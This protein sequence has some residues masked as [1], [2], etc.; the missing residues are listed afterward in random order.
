MDDDSRSPAEDIP[1]E[2]ERLFA[3]VM[4][5]L[6]AA[7]A[8][9][10]AGSDKASG[11]ARAYDAELMALRDEIGEARLEDVPA[12][13]AQMERL[14]EVSLTRADLQTMLVDPLSPYFGHLRL[15]ERVAGRGEVEREVFIGRATF[16]D[17]RTR[18]AIVDWRNAPV[19]Q[20]YYRYAEGSDYEETFGEREVEGDVLVRRT[21][22]IQDGTL[23]RIACP[24]GIWVKRRLPDQDGARSGSA[25]TCPCASWRAA[26]APPPG[27]FLVEACWDLPAR[28]SNDLTGTCPRSQRSSTRASSRS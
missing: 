3:R 24:Q 22:T 19:S 21:V 8:Q 16:T 26:N 18:I 1:A 25:R 11:R 10:P 4:Q 2:E 15:R 23:L 27:L 9:K 13:I 20:L 6:A 14:Q 12:L 5:S 28:T 17:P 7:A